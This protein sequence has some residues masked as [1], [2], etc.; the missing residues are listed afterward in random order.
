MHTA[1]LLPPS[2]PLTRLEHLAVAICICTAAVM[3]TTACSFNTSGSGSPE[4]NAHLMDNRRTKAPPMPPAQSAWLL[5]L[6][7]Y[8][9]GPSAY[10]VAQP[11]KG[12]ESATSTGQG[13]LNARVGLADGFE[14]DLGGAT[15]DLQGY[16]L[17]RYQ[18][19]GHAQPA[20]IFLA[21]EGG[22]AVEG[23][24]ATESEPQGATTEDYFG[25][26]TLG[27]VIDRQWQLQLSA[28]G[29]SAA[30]DGYLEA[31]T[32][33]V[34]RP[35]R[36]MDVVAGGAYR[37]YHDERPDSARIGLSF[38]FGSSAW[39]APPEPDRAPQARALLDQGNLKGA[40]RWCRMALPRD[41]NNLPLRQ[42]CA[43]VIQAMAKTKADARARRL[44]LRA[45]RKPAS[46]PGSQGS[47]GPAPGPVIAPPLPGTR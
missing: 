10:F 47:P 19:L 9:L 33:V 2:R 34:Y 40:Y 17:M 24:F 26:L 44:A 38:Q 39:P 5:G 35:L 42:V 36:L 13:G 31:G 27:K 21:A 4:S 28:R 37:V 3:C 22:A 45:K 29:G 43:E 30:D 23:N 20:E 1:P 14:L 7:E 8:R 6:G 18:V 41:R 16:G 11:A 25:G 12:N 32:G 46:A 15:P